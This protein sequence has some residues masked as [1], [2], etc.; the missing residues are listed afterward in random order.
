[1]RCQGE[2]RQSDLKDL[3]DT[4]VDKLVLNLVLVHKFSEVAPTD[5]LGN[6]VVVGGRHEAVYE[7]QYAHGVWIARE[8]KKNKGRQAISKSFSLHGQCFCMCI[9]TLKIVCFHVRQ[10]TMSFFIGGAAEQNRI[11]RKALQRVASDFCWL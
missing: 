7:L 2:E 8:H 9:K 11:K 6:D 5:V 1:M 10:N 3:S 4:L